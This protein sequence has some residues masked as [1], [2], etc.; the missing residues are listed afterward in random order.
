LRAQPAEEAGSTLLQYLLL[1]AANHQD[2]LKG[3]SSYSISHG[4]LDIR[5]LKRRPRSVKTRSNIWGF[6][7]PKASGTLVQ[8]ENKHLFN[9][10]SN[11]KMTNL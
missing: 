8:K 7:S 1:A 4:K 10:D 11:F 6:T 9:P 5:Y 3:Q 2:C